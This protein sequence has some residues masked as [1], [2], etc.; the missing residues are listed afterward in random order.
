MSNFNEDNYYVVRVHHKEGYNKQKLYSFAIHKSDVV[1]LSEY[2]T[3]VGITNSNGAVDIAEVLSFEEARQ[4]GWMMPTCELKGV[5]DETPYLNRKKNREAKK[6]LKKQ[7]DKRIE[8]LKTIEV[9]NLFA[10][11][12]DTLKQILNEYN[13]IEV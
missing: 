11:K 4:N 12:D 6:K 9:Y 1:K 10:E 2:S 5:F 13:E 3:P 8:E 7:M